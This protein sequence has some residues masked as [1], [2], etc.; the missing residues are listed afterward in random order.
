MG[1]IDD[2]FLMDTVMQPVR[3]TLFSQSICILSWGLASHKISVGL[4]TRA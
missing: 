2:F 3:K 1:H 4:Y